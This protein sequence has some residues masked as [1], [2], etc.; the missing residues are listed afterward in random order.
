M[1]FALIAKPSKSRSKMFFKTDVL[2]F[3]NILKKTPVSDTAFNKVPGLKACI[4]I[5]KETPI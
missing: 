3:Y 4:F 2:K 5:Y 1:L